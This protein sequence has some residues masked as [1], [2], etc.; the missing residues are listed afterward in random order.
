MS[1]YINNYY[2]IGIWFPHQWRPLIT[3]E[4][5]ILAAYFLKNIEGGAPFISLEVRPIFLRRNN[6]EKVELYAKRFANNKHLQVLKSGY[7]RIG[8]EPIQCFCL[9]Y[10]EPKANS[11]ITKQ[12]SFFDNDMTIEYTLAFSYRQVDITIDFD[13]R[14]IEQKCTRSLKFIS[15]IESE[16]YSD[17]YRWMCGVCGKPMRISLPLLECVQCEKFVDINEYSRNNGILAKILSFMW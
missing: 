2:S 12:Y 3:T 1:K 11:L 9:H 5:S 4:R 15:N 13:P 10:I 14:L 7:E 16:Y 17:D 8:Y 6:L